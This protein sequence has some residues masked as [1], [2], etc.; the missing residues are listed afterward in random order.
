MTEGVWAERRIK[1]A[2][3]AAAALVMA[4]LRQETAKA[5]R[6]SRMTERL[7]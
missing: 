4:D 6:A 3:E 2:G 1:A 5:E 7:G